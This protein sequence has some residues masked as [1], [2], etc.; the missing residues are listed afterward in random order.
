MEH[1]LVLPPAAGVGR[2]QFR[3][4]ADSGRR[5]HHARP[6]PQLPGQ[7][8]ISVLGLILGL[9]LA[10]LILVLFGY[11]FVRCYQQGRCW[12]RPD[13]V[14]NLHH[15]CG[16]RSVAV[17]LTPPF[18]ISGLLSEAGGGYVRFQEQGL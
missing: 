14:F 5:L 1:A 17:E 6:A 18:S 12:R 13:F 3:Q 15:S 4:P 16:L 7:E 8:P 9:G 10:L 11:A 2:G